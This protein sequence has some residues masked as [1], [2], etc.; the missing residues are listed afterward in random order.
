MPG[1]AHCSSGLESIAHDTGPRAMIS[2]MMSASVET[3]P[4]DVTVSLGYAPARGGGVG[5]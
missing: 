3:E 4:V 2:A 5:S 1:P